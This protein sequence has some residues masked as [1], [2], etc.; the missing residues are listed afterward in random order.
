VLC[1]CLHFSSSYTAAEEASLGTTEK[2]FN[3]FFANGFFSFLLG[4]LSLSG[5][6]TP[7][8][9]QGLLVVLIFT[10]CSVGHLQGAFHH[11]ILHFPLVSILLQVTSHPMQAHSQA[12]LYS[13]ISMD[14]DH[15]NRGLPLCIT[16]TCHIRRSMDPGYSHHTPRVLS[17]S[18]S[19]HSSLHKLP[20][21]PILHSP[22]PLSHHSQGLQCCM[23]VAA[24]IQLLH[25]H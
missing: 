22:I 15:N 7:W 24:Q 6:K 8:E 18:N 19:N 16:L 2:I 3:T 5:T 1:G 10:T 14:L 11:N 21:F 20:L 17:V 9:E 4:C 23:A 25:C 12:C 13:L